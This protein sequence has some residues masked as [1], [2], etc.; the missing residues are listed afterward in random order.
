MGIISHE[1]KWLR[2]CKACI[3]FPAELMTNKCQVMI[4]FAGKEYMFFTKSSSLFSFNSEHLFWSARE[5]GLML[6]IT[7]RFKLIHI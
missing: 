7:R 2:T 4:Y 1:Q 3:T 6:R 5:V